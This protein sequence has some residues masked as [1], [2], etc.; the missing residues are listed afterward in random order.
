MILT[1]RRSMA[2]AAM[3]P[4]LG[5][6]RRIWSLSTTTA[7]GAGAEPIATE[8]WREATEEVT[9]LRHLRRV[10]RKEKAEEGDEE[11]NGGEG[12]GERE[13]EGHFCKLVGRRIDIVVVVRVKEG[14]R[15]PRADT[16]YRFLMPHSRGSKNKNKTKSFGSLI[17][18]F[19]QKS[20][21]LNEKYKMF[22]FIHL[23][24]FN[25]FN[26]NNSTQI[27]IKGFST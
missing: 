21:F 3:R 11:R 10:P 7:A 5:R 8:D 15:Q 4:L 16:D 9:N 2:S 25:K 26:H 14:R 6:P 19:I 22:Y 20:L 13:G 12:E 18:W 23:F 17:F 27:Y 1:L 24:F